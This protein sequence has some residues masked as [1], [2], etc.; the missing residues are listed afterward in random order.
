[1]SPLY[2]IIVY[3]KAKELKQTNLTWLLRTKKKID[4]KVPAGENVWVAKFGKLSKYLEIGIQKLWHMETVTISV[5]TGD[6]G[7]I[8]KGLKNI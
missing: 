2:G 1:M 8:K 7:I 6:L 3:K 5:V 4:T